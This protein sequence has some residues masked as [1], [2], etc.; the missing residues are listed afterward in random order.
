M[1]F[2]AF[3]TI[4]GNRPGALSSCIW[5]GVNLHVMETNWGAKHFH[6][7]FHD[8]LEKGGGVGVE[9]KRHI[10]YFREQIE[11]RV[12]PKKEVEKPWVGPNTGCF[13][14]WWPLGREEI[15][16]Q[17]IRKRFFPIYVIFFKDSCTFL[18]CFYI[19]RNLKRSYI[20]CIPPFLQGGWAFYQI[21]KKGE[22]AWQD[23]NVAVVT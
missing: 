4:S 18:H 15:V 12:A 10:I 5:N 16:T 20:V 8:V 13:S 3:S 21:F 17:K 19:L 7:N 22:G 6:K 23:L 14:S 9:I 1:K 11:L 2:P